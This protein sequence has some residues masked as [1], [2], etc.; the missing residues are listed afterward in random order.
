MVAKT[1]G[2]GRP[3][4]KAFGRRPSATATDLRGAKCIVSRGISG[5]AILP[6]AYPNIGPNADRVQESPA[7]RELIPLR[8]EPVECLRMTDTIDKLGVA[9]GY[10]PSKGVLAYGL[11]VS[12]IILVYIA[13]HA[14]EDM[15]G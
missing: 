14:L 6:R 9:I 4:A 13:M 5:L 15:Q 11:Y 3:I 8:D 10:E 2:A 7:L 1:Y 12:I